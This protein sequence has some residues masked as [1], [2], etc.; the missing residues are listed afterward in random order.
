[1]LLIGIRQ[2]AVAFMPVVVRRRMLSHAVQHGHVVRDRESAWPSR[3]TCSGEAELEAGE[4]K[5]AAF[6]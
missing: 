3:R 2:G 1:M 4:V 6:A 5:L